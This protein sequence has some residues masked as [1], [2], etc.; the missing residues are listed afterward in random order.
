MFLS[1]SISFALLGKWFLAPP[2]YAVSL[3]YSRRM[4]AVLVVGQCHFPGFRRKVG[5]RRTSSSASHQNDFW[6]IWLINITPYMNVMPLGVTPSL[7]RLFSFILAVVLTWRPWEWRGRFP[8]WK[9]CIKVII[10]AAT[11]SVWNILIRIDNHKHGGD[12]AAVS[13]VFTRLTFCTL[14]APSWPTD[15]DKCIWTPKRPNCSVKIEHKIIKPVSYQ[16]DAVGR[17]CLER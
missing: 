13:R 17:V 10:N 15:P 11:N 9:F 2:S 7:Q 14:V 16:P 1:F 8:K 3:I 4:R 12:L 6:T 5:L